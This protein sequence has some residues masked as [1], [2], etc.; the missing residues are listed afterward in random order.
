VQRSTSQIHVTDRPDAYP[1]LRPNFST[2]ILIRSAAPLESTS[3]DPLSLTPSSPAKSAFVFA[4]P[5][6][7]VPPR[8]RI[9]D[10]RF[11]EAVADTRSAG[12]ANRFVVIGLAARVVAAVT[13][14]L[15]LA[16]VGRL[17]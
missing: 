8:A 12:E 5:R 2:F 7:V 10:G 9:S 16:A 4:A 3:T 6:S 15:I 14:S 17:Q 1:T 11:A 13:V